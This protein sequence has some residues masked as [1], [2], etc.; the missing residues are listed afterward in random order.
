MQGQLID[1]VRDK[2]CECAGAVQSQRDCDLRVL[3]AHANLLDALLL[4]QRRREQQERLGRAGAAPPLLLADSCTDSS[5]D[6][7]YSSLSSSEEEDSDEDSDYEYNAQY[8]IPSACG[9]ANLLTKMASHSD[10]Q[11]G[12]LVLPTM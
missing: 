6:D 7:E 2:L 11:L 1:T 9:S 12:R 3:V 5:S 4:E 10:P 8:G